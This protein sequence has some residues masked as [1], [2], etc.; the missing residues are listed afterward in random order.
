MYVFISALY[1]LQNST[2]SSRFR[3]VFFFF[4]NNVGDDEGKDEKSV[5]IPP[6]PPPPLWGFFSDVCKIQNGIRETLD[7]EYG[8]IKLD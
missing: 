4:M 3:V 8:E 1:Q 5:Q 6:S 2:V 7:W